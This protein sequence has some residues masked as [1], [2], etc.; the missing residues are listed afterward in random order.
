[1]T[2][3]DSVKTEQQ[4]RCGTCRFWKTDPR[5]TR[6]GK[7]HCEWRGKFLTRFDDDGRF[8]PMWEQSTAVPPMKAISA[9]EPW[10][11]ALLGPKDVE[12]RTWELPMRYLGVPLALHASKRR[13]Q[14]EFDAFYETAHRAGLTIADTAAFIDP[15]FGAVIGIITFDSWSKS[16][17][18]EDPYS[19][20]YVPGLYGWHR[21][22]VV[23]LPEPVR[24]RGALGIWQLPSDVDAAVRAQ[25]QEVQP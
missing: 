10:A 15:P 11:A 13:D 8:C 9:L 3:K 6:H 4:T 16:A 18:D 2:H 22:T 14:T 23:T 20:W 12:N 21:G 24:C 17:P 7:C 25:L 19:P 1:M 5:C